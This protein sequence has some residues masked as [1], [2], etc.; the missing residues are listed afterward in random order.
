[1]GNTPAKLSSQ[2]RTARNVA[3]SGAIKDATNFVK[4][5]Q[6]QV[7]EQASA[8]NASSSAGAL[9]LFG[10]AEIPVEAVLAA[11]VIAEKQ[12]QRE[13]HQFVKTDLIAILIALDPTL[14]VN[15]HKLDGYSC[16]DLRAKIRMLVYN[17]LRQMSSGSSIVPDADIKDLMV[18]QA[19]PSY[20]E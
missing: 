20:T 14:R 3:R 1:M 7:Q 10:K 6:V 12:L 2:D 9:V 19:P 11:T 15:V 16:D 5:V 17:P 8:S 13:G 18:L 4:A